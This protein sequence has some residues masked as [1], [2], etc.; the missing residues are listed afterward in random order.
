MIPEVVRR[1]LR[2]HAMVW[3][4]I[5]L[6]LAPIPIVSFHLALRKS[7]RLA[8]QSPHLRL[9]VGCHEGRPHESLQVRIEE[10]WTSSSPRFLQWFSGV[11]ADGTPR[12]VVDGGSV[13]VQSWEIDVPIALP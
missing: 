3:K 4:K 2:R 7:P 6:Y 10:G 8:S 1:Q 13:D 5:N 9:P 11:G 12:V